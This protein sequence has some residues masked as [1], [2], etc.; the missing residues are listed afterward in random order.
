MQ[1]FRSRHNCRSAFAAPRQ[2]ALRAREPRVLKYQL[3][4]MW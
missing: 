1:R 2:G 3:P 4:S